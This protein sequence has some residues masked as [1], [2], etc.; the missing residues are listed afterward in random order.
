MYNE[1]H[2]EAVS[3]WDKYQNDEQALTNLNNALQNNGQ[4]ITDNAERQKIADKTLKNASERAKEYGNQ[5]VANTKTLS[6]FKKEYE[7]EDP[8]KQVKPK[9]T[10]GLK[11]FASSALSSIGNAVV[12]A[13]TAMIAQQLISWGL[14]G[15]DAIVHYDDTITAK[16]D[17]GS[18]TCVVHVMPDA[19]YDA[20][21]EYAN[22]NGLAMTNDKMQAALEY[23]YR[24]GGNHAD[25]ANIA[26]EGFKKAYLNDK[27]TYLKSWFNTLQ[28]RPDGATDVPAGVSPLIGYF[29]SK[30]KKVGP[31][32]MQQLADILEISTPGVKKYDSWGSALKNQILQKY[33]SY[34]F[35][36][37]GIINKLIP[38]DMSTLLG[39]AIISNGDQGFIGAKVGES[40]MT[41]EFT[42]LLKPSIAAM[43]NFTNMFNPVTPTATNND[44]TINNEVNIN[45]ANMSND[46]DIQDVANKVSTIINKNMTR[47]WRKLR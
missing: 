37:G 46:L 14:Q 30:G 35:A 8:N 43:N 9:F 34:G 28:N 29:N 12:S 42:R 47:D 21:E 23:A 18:K 26:V 40:V 31:K 10:D 3:N 5:I 45:V 27:P 1:G 16:S 25:K 22:K 44:Y 7:V 33:K 38:A 32:E 41:E 36:T 20:I 39:K 24:N 19:H 15:I 13:G 6:D 4:T 17:F 2:A 11:S